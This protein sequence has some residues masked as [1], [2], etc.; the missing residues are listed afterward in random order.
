MQLFIGEIN[1]NSAL[2][3]AEEAK[4]FT[5]VLRGKVGQEICVTDGK[6]RMCKGKTAL[7]SNHLVE[8]ELNS[9][10]GDFEKRGYK[11]HI[12]IAPTK[13]I[14]RIEFF[15]EKAVEIGIDEI[16]FLKSFHSERKH[17]NIE[18]IIKIVDSAVKQSLKA[19]IPKINE[20]QRFNDFVK[21][22]HTENKLIA[23]CDNNFSRIALHSFAKPKTDYLIVIGPEGDFS[24]DEIKTAEENG[25]TGVSLGQQRFRTETAALNA[26]FGV[27]WANQ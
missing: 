13:N 16:S 12:A 22:N 1:G 17:I 14:D 8:I 25:F 19:Y 15:I 21:A 4:H 27:N 23:H 7:V 10:I 20:L 26:V 18:R 5:K 24:K 6:G 11:L 9:I 3:S 2:L